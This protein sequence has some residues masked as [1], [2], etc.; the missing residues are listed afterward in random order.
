MLLVYIKYFILKKRKKVGM[1]SR[2]GGA[3]EGRSDV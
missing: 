3:R 2:I 1:S